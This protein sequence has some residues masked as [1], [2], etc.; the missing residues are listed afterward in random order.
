MKKVFLFAAFVYACSFSSYAQPAPP[1]AP[2]SADNILKAA[3]QEAKKENKKVFIMFHASWCGWCHK[4]DNSMNDPTC[5]D[6]FEKNF[7]IRHLV[8]D[9]SKDKKDLENPGANELRTKYYG[10]G[11]GIPFWLVFDK[12]GK[13]LSDSKIHKEG[14]IP[15]G[16][17]NVGCPANEEEVTF[18]INLLKKST[19]LSAE[20][21]ARIRTRFRQNDVH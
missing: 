13:L 9:E 6:F 12:D 4:M 18:F 15:E 2:E 11:Q 5:K 1:P 7:V 20:D 14:E 8:V 16:G 3:L 10:D 17:Q 21:E 19:N